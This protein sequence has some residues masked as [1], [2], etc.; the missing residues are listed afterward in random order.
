[1]CFL[2]ATPLYFRGGLACQ[3]ENSVYAACYG[4]DTLF[5]PVRESLLFHLNL[6][7]KSHL[8][9]E[10]KCSFYLGKHIAGVSPFP[11]PV[12]GRT[13]VQIGTAG[14]QAG[15]SAALWLMDT[16]PWDISGAEPQSVF[17]ARWWIWTEQGFRC[18]CSGAKVNSQH[19]LA[20]LTGRHSALVLIGASKV[21]FIPISCFS[22]QELTCP[23][24]PAK[25]FIYA[26]P[27]L[28]SS[29]RCLLSHSWVQPALYSLFTI[30]RERAPGFCEPRAKKFKQWKC[31]VL[32]P[33]EM[34]G[35]D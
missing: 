20:Y 10:Y 22:F 18:D 12:A 1:M 8:V 25:W 17:W 9:K 16:V 21:Y 30:E 35:A 19:F 34:L 14:K 13:G 32:F 31:S 6:N 29:S 33:L 23:G 26:S 3:K 11:G 15:I 2:S 5:A 4:G 28:M 24:S 7:Q 27:S